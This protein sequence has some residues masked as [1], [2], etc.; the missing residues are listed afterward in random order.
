MKGV[1]M[2]ILI[3]IV[4]LSI[5]AFP[6]LNAEEE[7]WFD[8]QN[9]EMCKYLLEDPE[10][11]NNLTHEHHA[12][13]AGQVSICRV[14]PD[15]V[16]S[17]LQAQ[18]GMMETGKRLMKGEQVQ[19]CNM[20]KSLGDLIASGVKRDVIESGDTYI[21]VTTSAEPEVVKKIHAWGERTNREMLS[22][23]KGGN[24]DKQ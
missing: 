18:Q 3:S 2:R 23:E 21:V 1:F 8:M 10:L 4:A 9:C 11:L 20:C 5:I 13:S 19:L 22:I 15:Y 17:Y 24:Q 6:M 16:N 14:K 12:I 7:P